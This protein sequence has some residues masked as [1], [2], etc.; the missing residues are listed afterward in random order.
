MAYRRDLLFKAIAN[1][2]EGRLG[3]TKV[4]GELSGSVVIGRKSVRNSCST[5]I[6]VYLYLIHLSNTTTERSC[7]AVCQIQETP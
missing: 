3:Y 1:Q 7:D 6:D 5:N 2:P 4:Q